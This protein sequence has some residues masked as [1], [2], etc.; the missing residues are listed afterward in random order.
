MKNMQNYFVYI[1][2]CS[3]GSFYTGHTDNLEKRLYE[4]QTNY[5]ACYTSMRLPITLVYYETFQSRYEAIAAE[6]KIKGWSHSKKQAL[7]HNDFERIRILSKR[8]KK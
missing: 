4:H 1:L 3:D 7:I 5:H 2:K 8:S 6:R